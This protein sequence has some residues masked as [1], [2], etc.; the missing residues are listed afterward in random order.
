MRIY[1]KTGDVISAD[2]ADFDVNVDP[3]D[4][5]HQLSFRLLPDSARLR[6]WHPQEDE[7]Y[8]CRWDLNT[9]SPNFGQ[10]YYERIESRE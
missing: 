5:E 10:L 8:D 7:W 3:Y 4:G 2:D 9:D 6:Y 1:L